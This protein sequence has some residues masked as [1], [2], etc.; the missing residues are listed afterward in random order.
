MRV[1]MIGRRL[2]APDGQHIEGWEDGSVHEVT[3][4]HGASL[5]AA[6]WAT[7]ADGPAEHKVV[8]PREKKA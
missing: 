6:G 2:V 8:T 3:P 1:R 7:A 5:I 4:E